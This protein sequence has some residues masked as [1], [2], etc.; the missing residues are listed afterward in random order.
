LAE[1]PKSS[2]AKVLLEAKNT[3]KEVQEKKQGASSETKLLSCAAVLKA[4][5]QAA[6]LKHRSISVKGA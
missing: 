4:G 3:V 6:E 1:K 2:L 5:V